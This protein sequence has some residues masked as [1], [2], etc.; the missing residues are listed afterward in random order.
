MKKYWS[1]A[2]ILLAG[3]ALSAQKLK[4]VDAQEGEA[5]EHARVQVFTDDLTPRYTDDQGIVD[6]SAF[7]A[8]EIEISAMG[9]HTLVIN[10]Q[11]LKSVNFQIALSP[12]PLALD[13]VVISA[14]RWSQSSRE[15]PYHISGLK[16]KDVILQAPQTSADLLG[17]SGEVFIQK[18]QQ[19]GGSPMI[20]GFATNRLLIAVDGIRM[21]N[22]IFR[23]GNLQQVISIDP[24][25]VERNEIYFGP[26]SVIYGSDAI[27][28][29]MSFSTLSPQ[30]STDTNLLVFGRAYS[31][32]SSANRELSQHFDYN[33]GTEKWAWRGSFSY[34]RYGDLRMGSNGSDALLR[35]FWVQRMD[36]LDRVITNPDPEL[37]LN[38]GFEQF[39]ILQK[40]YY[41]AGTYLD[42]EYSFL[43]S[44]TGNYDRYD[45]LIRTRRGLP[46]SAQWY[47]GP[48]VWTMH[49]LEANFRKA[50]H[51][52]DR[53]TLRLAWQNFE[54]SR[55]DRDFQ[56]TDLVS[57]EEELNALS[58]NFDFLKRLSADHKVFYGIEYIN[59]QLNSEGSIRNIETN[60]ISKGAARYPDGTWQS[61]AAYFNHEWEWTP[62]F[63]SQAGVRYNQFLIATDFS[64]NQEFYPL[65]FSEAE[66]N[67]GNLT[68]S[69]GFVYRP[70]EIWK[71]RLNFGTAFR[72][73]NIDDIGKVF[74]SGEAIV[75]V[76]NPDLTAEYAYN[77]EL[78]VASI[79]W[80]SLRLD[81]S[82][83]YTF[84]NNALLRRPF[85]LNGLD[86][87][88]YDGELSQVQA[89]QNAASAQ[90]Y[91]LQFG[92]DWSI[93][94][95]WTF[96]NRFNWQSGEEEDENG[97][98]GPSRHAAPWFGLSRLRFQHRI[99]LLEINAQYSGAVAAE[100]LNFEESAKEYIYLLNSEGR[101][102]SPGWYSLNFKSSIEL[103]QQWTISAGIENI[104]SQRYRPYSSGLVAPGR[105]FILSARFKF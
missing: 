78:G 40:L 4:V 16:A 84:L 92:L 85:L 22:A 88:L 105:N 71:W 3:Y 30:L 82:T 7:R 50:N 96:A 8:K 27:G 93:N 5:I 12:S 2:L 64:D 87:I 67:T 51:F 72:A 95:H 15:L 44:R 20:R 60:A 19:G 53:A 68:G 6:I 61:I 24:L 1:L 39:H 80:K 36:S 69:L 47:Y 10:Y 70:S 11:D 46:R 49:K 97:N 43:H 75:V 57:R 77:A 32:T 35:T 63:T 58:F 98:I 33:I 104:T 62:K 83:Y 56:D 55:H 31:R 41:K 48:Q 37:Q 45:R 89:V 76:P 65:P 42:F 54:E 86:S 103:N 28:G 81:F 52:F 59:N 14:S 26:G 34:N 66:L 38:T 25:A 79:L 90:V 101:A 102:Y 17:S 29:V 13:Q 99:M 9:Y 100:D 73:P 91:G 94:D 18:S 74:D 21:N 23:S